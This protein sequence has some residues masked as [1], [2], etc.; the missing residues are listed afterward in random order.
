V[1]IIP[2]LFQS[3]P[4]FAYNSFRPTYGFITRIYFVTHSQ[5]SFQLLFHSY[6]LLKPHFLTNFQKPLFSLLFIAGP[7]FKFYLAIHNW[8]SSLYQIF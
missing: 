4:L 2:R 6:F 1:K 7:L 8:Y 3:Y 5:F